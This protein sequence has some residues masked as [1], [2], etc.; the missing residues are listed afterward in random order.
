MVRAEPKIVT[1]GVAVGGEHA[2]AARISAITASMI[3]RSSRSGWSRINPSVSARN[4][5]ASRDSAGT[6]NSLSS[7]RA[8]ASHILRQTGRRVDTTPAPESGPAS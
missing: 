3:L 8:R 1:F 6:P 7:A 4:S 2:K 5:S